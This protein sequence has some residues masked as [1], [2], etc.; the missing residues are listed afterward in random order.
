MISLEDKQYTLVIIAEAVES[1]A[2]K[3]MACDT[4]EISTRTL[5]RWEQD[6]V[7][8]RRKGAP[9][10]VAR[11]LSSAEEAEL[12][13]IACSSRFKDLNPHEIV[14]ILAE[15]G[16]YIASES[17]FYRYLRDNGLIHHRGNGKPRSSNVKPPELA[18]TGPNQV[19]SPLCQH[20]CRLKY[21]GVNYE[22]QPKNQRIDLT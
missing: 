21:L 2:R 14:P 15:E 16:R 3:L 13:D 10:R 12:L 19:W 20:S 4:L 22:I 5:Q 11:K 7:A 8:D 1:G 9:K 18:T 6:C 17:S